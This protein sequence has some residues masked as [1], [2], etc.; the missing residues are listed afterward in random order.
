MLFGRAFELAVA[1]YFR[2]ED[3][4]AVLYREWIVHRGSHGH[5]SERDTWDRMLQ[6]GIQLLE[7]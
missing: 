1:A 4:A 7:A 6:S 2:R 3:A 5:Y